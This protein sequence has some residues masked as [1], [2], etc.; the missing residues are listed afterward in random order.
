MNEHQPDLYLEFCRRT[1]ARY[2]AIRKNHYVPDRGCHGQQIHF[3]IWYRGKI[4][5]IISG[6]S[7]VFATYFRDKFFGM[8]PTNK[9]FCLN[10][11]IDNLLFRIEYHEPNLATR[12]LSLWRSAVTH[13]WE[14]LYEV[15]VF[16]FETFID[17][18]RFGDPSNKRD[19]GLYKA[20]NWHVLGMTRG[21][22]K[23]H[24]KEGLNGA[25]IGKPSI[26]RS[27]P[28][29]LVACRWVDLRNPVPIPSEY[30]SCWRN[31]TAEERTRTLILSKRRKEYE[32]MIFFKSGNKLMFLKPLARLSLV[33]P[34]S[35]SGP[36]RAGAEDDGAGL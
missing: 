34:T 29:K 14:D 8:T 11:I 19:G 7:A 23:Q 35:G 21:S 6:A 16:G 15:K 13:A 4:V 1:D 33:S 9:K 32:G 28:Q 5:G 36:I 26:R 12:I 17:A 27:V 3:L 20:D 2:Q 18:E 25:Q 31:G 24:G 22:T 10:G 30:K